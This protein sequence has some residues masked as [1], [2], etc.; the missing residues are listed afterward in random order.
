MVYNALT[1]DMIAAF[2]GIN[3]QKYFSCDSFQM[4]KDQVRTIF[5]ICI[6]QNCNSLSRI[7]VQLIHYLSEIYFI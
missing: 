1:N 4:T 3:K 6:L 7:N 2:N 5:A